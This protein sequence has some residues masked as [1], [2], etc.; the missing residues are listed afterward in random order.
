MAYQLSGIYGKQ[1]VPVFKLRKGRA[2]DIV[3]M[4]V[5]IMLEGQVSDSWLSGDNH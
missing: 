5:K 4:A 1:S 2:H 3:D